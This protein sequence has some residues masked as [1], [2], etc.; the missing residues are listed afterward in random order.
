MARN[1]GGFGA[2]LVG[3]LMGSF[4]GVTIAFLTAPRSGEETRE[5]IRAKGVELRDSAGQTADEALAT[6]KTT[7]LDVSSRV[8]AL[9]A[10]SQAALDEAQGQWAQAIQEIKQV[11]LEAIEEVRT[12]AAEAAQETEKPAAEAQ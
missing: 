12:A 8:E 6:V 3:F 7:A 11:A 4:V 10:Q 5:Q 9:R 2:F 1:N